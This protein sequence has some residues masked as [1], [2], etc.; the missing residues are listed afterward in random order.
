MDFVQLLLLLSLFFCNFAIYNNFII[1]II[2]TVKLV[3]VEHI[4]LIF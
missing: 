4:L 2:G 1:K 3:V